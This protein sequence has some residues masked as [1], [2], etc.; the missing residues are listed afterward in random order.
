M[1]SDP[2]GCRMRLVHP[3]LT[4]ALIGSWVSAQAPSTPAPSTPAPSTSTP[5]ASAQRDQVEQDIFEGPKDFRAFVVKTTLGTD[6]YMLKTQNLITAAMGRPEDGGLG[7]TYANDKTRTVA[8]VW[9]D[10]KANCMSLTA[11]YV[12][13]F[14]AIGLPAQ[15]AEAPT[16]NLWTRSGNLILNEHHVVAYVP[17]NIMTRLVADFSGRPHTGQL[18]IVPI[19]E[20]RFRALFHSNRAVELLLAGDQDGAEAQGRQAVKD[21]PNSGVAWNAL[22]AVEK[23]GGSKA[24]AEQDFRTA[25][26]VDSDN[27]PACGNLET[28][29]RENGRLQEADAYREMGLKIREKDP[30]FQAFLAKEALAGGR[31]E[32]AITR[33]NRALKL[34]RTEPDFYLILAQAELNRGERNEAEKAVEKAIRWSLPSQRKRME[35]KLDLIK[36]QES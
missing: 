7:I 6:S 4:L 18:P 3:L 20:A 32:E 8:E 13:A 30:Y 12:A 2:S 28:L 31:L 23:M 19:S 1:A 22:G 14:R 27:G 34:Q 21:D 29:Y 15:F 10:R 24:A 17:V 36:A 35:S 33:V 16:I 26:S 11:F 5:S 9:R 25:L